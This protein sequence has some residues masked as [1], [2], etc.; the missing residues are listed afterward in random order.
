[1]EPLDAFAANV[2]RLRQERGLTQERLAELS[3]LHMTDIA[4]IETQ[5][6]DPGVKIIAKIAHGLG[7][8]AGLLLENVEYR[9]TAGQ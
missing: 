1:M 3:D 6:R 9:P 8:P 7:V 4:R 2:R 5:G